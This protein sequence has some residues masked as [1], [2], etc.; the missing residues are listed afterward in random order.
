MWIDPEHECAM[1]NIHKLHSGLRFLLRTGGSKDSV[2]TQLYSVLMETEEGYRVVM[3][4]LRRSR[5]RSEHVVLTE[6]PQLLEKVK[7]EED[8]FFCPGFGEAPPHHCVSARNVLC[9]E[10]NCNIVLC[11]PDYRSQFPWVNNTFPKSPD[12]QD[13]LPEWK[14]DLHRAPAPPAARPPKRTRK[15]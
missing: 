7:D 9:G 11:W 14:C 12:A 6:N 13:R 8:Y 15:K 2:G 5:H 4:L 1:E 3:E 10:D